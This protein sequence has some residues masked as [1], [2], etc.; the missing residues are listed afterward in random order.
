MVSS[1]R[2]DTKED[3]FV[4]HTAIK[5]NNLRKYLRS[6][7]GET[8]EFDVIEG[9]K[10]TEAANGTGLCK[11]VNMQQTVAII[12]TLHSQGSSMPLPKLPE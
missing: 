3:I 9:E 6:V 10:G 12:D 8:V 5:K 7:G 11:A 2:S 1:N 4:H